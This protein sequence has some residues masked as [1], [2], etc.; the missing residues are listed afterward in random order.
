[1]SNWRSKLRFEVHGATHAQLKDRAEQ[2]IVEYFDAESYENV[3]NLID[4]E[5]ESMLD[6]TTLEYKALVYVKIK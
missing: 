4:V 3:T 5:M 2:V 6:S 1:M